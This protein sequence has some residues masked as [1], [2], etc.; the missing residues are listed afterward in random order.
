MD[1]IIPFIYNNFIFV[2]ICPYC[3]YVSQ[4]LSCIKKHCK[5]FYHID[6][7]C[8]KHLNI[9]NVHDFLVNI[10]DRKYKISNIN[11]L[12]GNCIKIFSNTY[13]C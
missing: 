11:N 3:E 1:F 7:I 8:S 5:S 9:D 12:N 4:S 10:C 6:N 2:Y 13:T